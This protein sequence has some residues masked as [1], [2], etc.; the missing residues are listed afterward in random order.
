[1]NTDFKKNIEAILEWTGDPIRQTYSPRE[2][3]G[4]RGLSF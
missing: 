4:Q 2:T 1:M 3:G